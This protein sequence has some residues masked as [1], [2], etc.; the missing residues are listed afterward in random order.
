MVSSSKKGL[1][2]LKKTLKS[3]DGQSVKVGHFAE[4]GEHYSGLSYP[5]LMA[6]HHFGRVVTPRKIVS[7]FNIRMKKIL[8]N[9]NFTVAMKAWAKS[10]LTKEDSNKLLEA[11]GSELVNQEKALFGKPDMFMPPTNSKKAVGVSGPTAPLVDRGDL[12]AATSYATS[13]SKTIKGTSK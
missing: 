6:V 12:R 10:N 1:T 13:L 3:L 11:F 8:T 5:D 9:N 4:S 2:E 7:L